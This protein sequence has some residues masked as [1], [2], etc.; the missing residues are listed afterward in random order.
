MLARNSKDLH[1][2]HM[3]PYVYKLKKIG[4]KRERILREHVR[5]KGKWHDSYIF[6]IL[7][8]ELGKD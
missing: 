7:E 1:P 2:S 5:A 4:M 8:Q 3:Y 6:S